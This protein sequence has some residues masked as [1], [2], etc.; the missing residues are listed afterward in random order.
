[1]KL[2]SAAPSDWKI[3]NINEKHPEGPW[4]RYD[5]KFKNCPYDYIAEQNGQLYGVDLY[6]NGN[7]KKTPINIEEFLRKH[8]RIA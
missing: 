4:I 5:E 2:S 1:M 7:S 3:G 8:P 6:W